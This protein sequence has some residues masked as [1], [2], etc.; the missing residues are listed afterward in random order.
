[1]DFS[2]QHI[3]SMFRVEEET[4]MKQV[5]SK[6]FIVLL[7]YLSSTYVILFSCLAYYSTL[8]MEAT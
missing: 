1:M 7:F 5:A 8:K 2:E 6:T 3:A 4:I